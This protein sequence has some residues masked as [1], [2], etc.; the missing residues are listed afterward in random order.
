MTLLDKE[1]D[2]PVERKYK[3]G[4]IMANRK[5]YAAQNSIPPQVSLE[6][7]DFLALHIVNDR[8]WGDFKVLFSQDFPNFY[9]DLKASSIPFS[10]GDLRLL[11]LVYLNLSN[12]D[13]ADKLSISVDGIKSETTSKRKLPIMRTAV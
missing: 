11:S 2:T 10:E 5:P 7:K 13:L 4:D 8:S 1:I 9:D 12:R 3:P 6:L